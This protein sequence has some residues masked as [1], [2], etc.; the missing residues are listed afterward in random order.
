MRLRAARPEDAAAIA[1]IYTPFVEGSFVSFEM[2]A[3][4]ETA[5]RER[6]LAGGD[7]YPWLAAEN[8]DDVAGYAYAAA[9]RTRPAYRFTV[10]TSVYVVPERSG[11]GV[12]GLL[13]ARLMEVLIAQGYVHAIAAITEPN[14]ASARFHQRFGFE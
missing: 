4:D 7:L 9:F 10:E 3:P 8:G 6:I 12:G 5:M 14:P 2:E 11:A 13:Y 1:A